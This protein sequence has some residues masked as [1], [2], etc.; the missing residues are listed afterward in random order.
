MP[1]PDPRHDTADVAALTALA[2]GARHPTGLGRSARARSQPPPTLPV[3]S[4]ERP[5]RGGAWD[6]RG[7]LQPEYSPRR[8][9]DPDPGEVVWA[10]VPYREDPSQGKDRPIVVIGRDADDAEVLVALMLSSKDHD[11]DAEWWSIGTGEWDREGRESWVRLDRPLA[12]TED[13]V[14]REGAILPEDVF[15]S[16]VERAGRR[17]VPSGAGAPR[18]QSPAP[19][20]AKQ[21]LLSRL[22]RLFRRS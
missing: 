15:L 22:G 7:R 21:G 5:E 20:P 11:H 6:F 16:I 1:G 18:P 2:A 10:W 3:M 17:A 4:V 12:V 13:G 14:R 19:A 9:G 8:D